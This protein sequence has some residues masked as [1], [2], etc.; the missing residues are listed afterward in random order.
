MSFSAGA[1]CGL[2]TPFYP[3]L[4]YIHRHTYGFASVCKVRL[5]SLQWYHHQG[6]NMYAKPV[7]SLESECSCEKWTI[8]SQPII[9]SHGNMENDTWHANSNGLEQKAL[10]CLK[11]WQQLIASLCMWERLCVCVKNDKKR[12][13]ISPLPVSSECF[14]IQL[15]K[16]ILGLRSL[17]LI[18]TVTDY[19]SNYT[20]SF[21]KWTN[22]PNLNCSAAF[23]SAALDK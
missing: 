7:S 11:Q 5:D 19:K 3:P 6:K 4:F 23:Q 18:Q 8:V 12:S 2:R 13:L 17:L 10:L 9:M 21:Q 1:T 20:I 22:S 15:A 14:V 16:A